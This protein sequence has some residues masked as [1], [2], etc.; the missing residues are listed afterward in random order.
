MNSTESLSKGIHSDSAN[1]T[2]VRR[3]LNHFRPYRSQAI[4]GI[5]LIPV[6][7]VFSILFPWMIM[8]VIDQQ[9]VP[10]QYDGLMWWAAALVAVLLGNYVADAAYNY[11][12]MSAA[13]SA[14]RDIRSDMF[15]RVL[16]FP[17]RYFDKTPMGVT[18]TRL[19][20][21]L[22][23][24][25]ESFTQGL[26]SMVR[27]VLIT[28]ALLVFL[29]VISW[30]LTLVL[31]FAGPLTVRGKATMIDH[32]W[33]VYS[34]YMHQ[35]EILVNVGDTVEVGQVIGLVGGTGTRLCPCTSASGSTSIARR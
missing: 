26:L 24:I 34:G 6:S 10:A 27:D 22:E 19:T 11:S 25:S 35:S 3:F 20:S 1:N 2:V 14:I 7:V 31:I 17:R 8:Q 32:G 33:G 5:S 4:L 18:L 21:D 9:L 28:V 13:Q 23:A 16:H 15:S 30:K 12:L 29:F